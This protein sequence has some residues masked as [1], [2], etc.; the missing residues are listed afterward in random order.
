MLLP[1]E[2]S[3]QTVE[4]LHYISF[5]MFRALLLLLKSCQHRVCDD[6]YLEG[7]AERTKF[8]IEKEASCGF[9]KSAS[10]GN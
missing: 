10:Q 1:A 2:R 4:S 9:P 8:R 3:V 7:R 6:E 5:F